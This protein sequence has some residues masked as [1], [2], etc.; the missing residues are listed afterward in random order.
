L[1]IN[2]AFEHRTVGVH[3]LQ[4][5]LP[6]PKKA[7]AVR[8]RNGG[9]YW[10]FSE[11][12]TPFDAMELIARPDPNQHVLITYGLHGNQSGGHADLHDADEVLNW[13]GLKHGE[14]SVNPIWAPYTDNITFVNTAEIMRRGDY[15]TLHNVIN[16]PGRVIGGEC[17]STHS[18]I[19]SCAL[20]G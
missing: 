14:A 6:G 7:W 15:E 9:E 13:Y 1:F 17:F 10:G 4:K 5:T 20:F 3:F 18:I 2:N 16:Y 19:T 8:N 11:P 12:I